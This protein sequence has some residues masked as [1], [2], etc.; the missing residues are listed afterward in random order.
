MK[1]D[2]NLPDHGI[3]WGLE[4]SLV[5][6]KA[7]NSDDWIVWNRHTRKVEEI[8]IHKPNIH[9]WS[10]AEDKAKERSKPLDYYMN[11]AIFDSIT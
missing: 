6:G 10:D 7:I 1:K 8:F 2:Y 5:Y 4:Y 3:S 11:P 9:G